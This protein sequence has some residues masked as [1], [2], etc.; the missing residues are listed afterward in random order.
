MFYGPDGEELPMRGFH[1]Q[2]QSERGLQIEG[3]VT[4]VHGNVDVEELLAALSVLGPSMT[5]Q[6][7]MRNNAESN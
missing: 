4:W 5:E 2:M 1:V 6:F 7:T 3:T